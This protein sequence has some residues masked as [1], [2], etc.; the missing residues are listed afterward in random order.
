VH[1]DLTSLPRPK[2]RSALHVADVPEH[3]TDRV[4][5][6]LHRT[7]TPLHEV[8]G[9]G[10]YAAR[11]AH[12]IGP[13]PT[14]GAVH[15]HEDGTKKLVIHLVD[16]AR[17]E[18]VLV[19]M[20]D[21]RFTLCVSSQVGCAMAC[22]FCATGTLG[23]TRNLTADE[24]VSQFHLARQLTGGDARALTRV[25][26]MGMGEPLAAYDAVLD[27]I[28]ILR[29]P[30]GPGLGAKHITVSTVGL[31][32]KIAQ[33]AVDTGGRI[34][35]A[36]SLHA[37]TDETRRQI[38]PAARRWPL[39]AL[40]SALHAWPLPGSRAL[41]IEVVVL[42]GVNDDHANLDGIA[43]FM[44][45]LRGVVNLIP[46]NPF[47]SAPF[48]SP[49]DAEVRTMQQGLTDRGVFSRVRWPRGRGVSGACGQ[50]M[51]AEQST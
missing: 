11:L 19:P 41:M 30:H 33:L 23:L 21:D 25:V 15:D 13:R 7:R 22:S 44:S 27:A 18:S 46:F 4:F 16:G 38:V 20:R 24:I 28:D 10:R 34:Q 37:G 35:L 5:Q 49:T 43:S 31:V 6:A 26:F 50:L 17:V 14:L 47:P 3:H 29:D 9:L 45:G 8:D 32:P 48:R 39:E 2:L 36:L 40:K 12:Q 1:A 51:L 42:P